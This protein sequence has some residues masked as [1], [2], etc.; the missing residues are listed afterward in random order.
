MPAEEQLISDSSNI[1]LSVGKQILVLA[2]LYVLLSPLVSMPLYERI[3]FFPDRNLDEGAIAQP[4][5]QLHKG[6]GVEKSD[7]IIAAP[8][9]N[10]LYG[11]YLK[12]PG[13]TKVMLVS[14]GNAGNITSRIILAAALLV[15]K[16]SVLLYDYEGY[17]KSEGSPSIKNVCDDGV[18]AFDYLTQTLQVKP[19]DI[20]VYGES[21]GSGVTC[22]IAS[23]RAVGGI[24]LQSGFPSLVYA[25]HD[26]LWLTWLYPNC[27]FKNLDNLAVLE[28][29]HAPLLI[30]QGRLDPIFPTRYAQYMYDR[31]SAPKQ[32]A[33]VDNL[34][35]CVEQVNDGQFLKAVGTYLLQ[36]PH[37]HS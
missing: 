27:W 33:L 1:R 34:G 13:A 25:A 4:V 7:V 21:V 15:C 37:P 26:R 12:M 30:I 9:G 23:C 2:G 8:D 35:H 29:P 5:E 11:W 36:F 28:K 22:H 32:L 20:I 6:L 31:A 24:V 16:T 19:S 17:G 14:H 18:A 10:K 3:L